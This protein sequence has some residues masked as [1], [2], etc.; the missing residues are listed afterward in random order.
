MEKKSD[1]DGICGMT[2][3]GLTA[4]APFVTTQSTAPPSPECC[5]ALPKANFQCFCAFKNSGLLGFYGIDF[6]QAMQLPTKCK[7]PNSSHC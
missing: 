4:C 3:E 6:N 1:T 5:L 2:K 7:L